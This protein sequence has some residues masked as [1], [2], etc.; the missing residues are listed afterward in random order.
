VVDRSGA[1]AVS[2]VVG[3]VGPVND[4]PVAVDDGFLVIEDTPVVIAVRANDSD[5][6]GDALSVTQ[7]NGMPISADGRGVAV[8]GGVVTLNSHGNLIFV[9]SLNFNGAVQFSYAVTDPKGASAT[10]TVTGT[11]AAVND[12]PTARDDSFS[13]AAGSTVIVWVRA[14]DGDVDGDA[15]KLTQVNGLPITVG[16][17]GVALTQ[18]VVTLSATGDLI[19]TPL[20][21]AS[22]AVEFS[23][24]VAD[25]SGATATA[26]AS[27]WVRASPPAPDPVPVPN[28]APEPTPSPAPDPAPA[29]APVPAPAPAPAPA[30]T[31]A[32]APAPTP[33]PAPMPAPAPAPAPAPMPSP[34]PAPVLPS[35]PPAEVPL[36]VVR[37]PNAGRPMD[38]EVPSPAPVAS[39]PSL[40]AASALPMRAGLAEWRAV[41]GLDINGADWGVDVASLAEINAPQNDDLAAAPGLAPTTVGLLG[42]ENKLVRQHPGQGGD[43]VYVTHAVRHEAFA[44]DPTLHVQHA[45]RTSQQETQARD[46]RALSNQGTSLGMLRGFDP[47]APAAVASVAVTAGTAGI[48]LQRVPTEVKA[49]ASASAEVAASHASSRPNSRDDLSPQP[50]PTR[51][52]PAAAP[53]FA[54]QLQ[55]SA[56]QFRARLTASAAA[57]PSSP[58]SAPSPLSTDP[59]TRVSVATR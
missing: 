34:A 5:V 1:Y 50:S 49:S 23:Y 13:V 32:P 3:W 56:E 46:L 26:T 51:H 57:R 14:N 2:T 47:F 10:A 9:P 39:A 36:A 15:L 22:G 53:G 40:P 18:G 28:P 7:V 30:P 16:G 35:G 11:V 54:A 43:A 45:V 37:L 44:T 19:F 27:G 12:A 25:P 52:R 42:R 6:D 21:D 58:S 41:T 8:Q 24:T 29:P 4:A 20:A 17:P 33:Q 31:P 55:H 48:D 59:N 38:V